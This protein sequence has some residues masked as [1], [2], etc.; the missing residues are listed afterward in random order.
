[1]IR[2][3]LIVLALASLL[4]VAAGP[5]V[6]AQP[7]GGEPPMMGI[8]RPLFLDELFRPEMLMRSQ[9]ELGLTAEQ[10]T[11]ITD[12]IKATQ[13]R[14]NTLQWDLAAKN[15][16]V[17]KLVAPDHIDVEAALAA[18]SQ[19]IDFEGQIKKEHLKLLLQIKNVLTPEQIA[20]L[21]AQRQDRCRD[22]RMGPPGMPGPGHGHGGP[23]PDDGPL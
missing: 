12:A 4:V 17:A 8:G 22:D 1:V 20:K 16:A 5:P 10:R 14:L 9:G 3:S 15:E 21:R 6:A 2:G 11:A 19:T 7:K 23:P 18:A 13:D